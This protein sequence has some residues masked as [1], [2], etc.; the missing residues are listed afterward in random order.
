MPQTVKL[1][2]RMDAI[3]APIIAVIGD[4]IRRTPGTISLG[5]GVVHYGPPPAALKAAAAAI[6]NTSTHEYQP[7]SG[8]PA[9]IR[10]IAEKL[11][12]DNG[13][14]VA[15]GSRIMVTAGAN[16]AFVHAVLAVTGPGDEVILPVPFYFNHEMAVQMAGCRVVPVATDS[17][18]Q[19]DVDAMRAAV[20]A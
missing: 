3:Q 17:R 16:M 7:A 19:L 9:L 14:D 18:Y 4:L 15:R 10:A 1:T 5:Q 20:T 12:D 8:Q 13:I 2:S 11:R 6:E